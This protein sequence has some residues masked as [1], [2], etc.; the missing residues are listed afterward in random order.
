MKNLYS[1]T[2]IPPILTVSQVAKF[3]SISRNKAYQLARSDQLHT[4]KI[5]N[6]IRV[7]RHALLRYLGIEMTT[8]D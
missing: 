2:E 1:E 4:L 7:P 3:L 6:S 8:A 5:G